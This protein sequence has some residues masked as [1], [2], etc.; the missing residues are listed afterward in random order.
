MFTQVLSN[1]YT[2]AT[3]AST[4]PL[5]QFDWQVID[6]WSTGDSPVIDPNVITLFHSP[7]FFLF[8]SLSLSLSLYLSLTPTE[9]K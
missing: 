7:S 6:R 1:V 5:I 3:G 8:L 2:V 4:D 9:C